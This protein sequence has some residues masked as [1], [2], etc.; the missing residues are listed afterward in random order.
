MDR[1]KKACRRRKEEWGNG[2]RK[3]DWVLF[4]ELRLEYIGIE[5]SMESE[6]KKKI[7]EKERRK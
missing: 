2:P 1:Q 4:L 7:E 5:Y 6:K 3:S